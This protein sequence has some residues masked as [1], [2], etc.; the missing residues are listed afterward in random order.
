L[1]QTGDTYNIGLT[2][3]T[4]HYFSSNNYYNEKL[5]S[6][7]LFNKATRVSN[8]QNLD[9]PFALKRERKKMH[10]RPYCSIQP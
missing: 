8:H 1:G 4:I 5:T 2:K 9:D 6:Q 3:S 7:Y 10:Q